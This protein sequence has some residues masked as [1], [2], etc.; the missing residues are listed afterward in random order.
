MSGCFPLWTTP[1]VIDE[2][3]TYAVLYKP[4]CL[5]SAPLSED[6]AG[7]LLGW[8]AALCPAVLRAGHN[9][10]GGLLHRLDCETEGLVLLAKTR[11]AFASL[12]AQQAVGHFVKEYSALSAGRTATPP[13]F[14]PPPFTGA[15]LPALPLFIESCFRPWGPGRKAVRPFVWDPAR[16]L[17]PGRSRGI[18][19]DQ[20]GAY[21]TEL[22]AAGAPPASRGTG[23]TRMFTLRIHRGFRHQIRCHLAWIG[24][25]ILNDALYGGLED[26]QGGA[27]AGPGVAEASTRPIALRARGLCFFDPATGAPRDYRLPGF[28]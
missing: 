20:G 4:P 16:P 7:T 26:R 25:P 28:D 19:R 13:G 22:L 6:P 21:R 17:A 14:P 5:F 24:E 23:T 15:A 27:S 8:F 12:R 11:E 3:D 10:E 18:A 9:R 1:R 2:T